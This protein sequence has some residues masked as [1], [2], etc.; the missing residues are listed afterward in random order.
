MLE[1]EIF[2]VSCMEV[3][4][5]NKQVGLIWFVILEDGTGLAKKNRFRGIHYT[6]PSRL[7]S[8]DIFWVFC[9]T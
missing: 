9:G 6:S 8:L 3:L 7:L 5:L 1:R 2:P 4:Q